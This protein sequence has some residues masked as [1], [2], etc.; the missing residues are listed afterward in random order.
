[1]TVRMRAPSNRAHV[2]PVRGGCDSLREAFQRS[3][4]DRADA[5][6][7]ELADVRRSEDS[8]HADQGLR[9]A[10]WSSGFSGR[11]RCSRKATARSSS[12]GPSSV[13][14]SHTCSSARTISSPPRCSSTRCGARS[15]PRRPAMRSRATPRTF[16]R[17][18][19]PNGSRGAARAIASRRQPSELDAA[20]VPVHPAG[21]SA[22][23]ADRPDPR[24]RRLQPRARSMARP[25]LRG[26]RRRD[27]APS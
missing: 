6:P 16:G 18:S 24:C 13:R 11:S 20:A 27:V 26:P 4:S 25:G 21:R 5:R 3:F 23:A 8:H 9:S 10:A 7:R 1:M 19:A 22:A 14:Y 17:R 15:H 2:G 12:E